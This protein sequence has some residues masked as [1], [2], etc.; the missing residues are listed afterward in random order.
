[1]NAITERSWTGA[2]L[3]SVA[4]DL[5]TRTLVLEMYGQRSSRCQRIV[6]TNGDVAIDGHLDTE[7]GPPHCLVGEPLWTPA[8][9]DELDTITFTTETLAITVSGGLA[10]VDGWVEPDVLLPL[11]LETDGLAG[12]EGSSSGGA[13]EWPKAA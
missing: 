13:G 5:N 6:I 12:W 9:N 4:F 10:S 1:M 7:A 11:W 2:V 3:R 8:A